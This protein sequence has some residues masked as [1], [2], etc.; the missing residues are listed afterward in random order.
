MRIQPSHVLM[1]LSAAAGVSAAGAAGRAFTAADLVGLARISDP[2]L[3]ADGRWLAYVVSELDQA[4]NKRRSDIWLQDLTQKSAPARRLTADPANDTSP[5]WAADGNYLY[6]LSARSGSTQLW[7]I[8]PRGGEAQAVSSL[9]VD[10]G[11]FK[12]APVGSR[13]V[14]SLDVYPDCADLACT[15]ERSKQDTAKQAT[16]E[17]HDQLFVRHWD[18]WDDGKRS[19]LFGAVIGADG[20]LSQPVALSAAVAAN[21]PSRPFGG[22]EEYTLSNDGERVIFSARLANASEAWSTNFDLYEVD[23]AGGGAPRNL[24]A[25]NPA[26]DSEPVYLANGDLA[27]LAMRRP[28]FES[29]RFGIM[30]RERSGKTREV[31]PQWDRSVSTLAR[32]TDGKSLLAVADDLGQHRLFKVDIGSGKVTALT[33]DGQVGGFTAGPRGIIVTQGSLVHPADLYWLGRGPATR[34]STVNDD[35]LAGISLGAAEPFTFSGW[36]NETVHGYVVRPHGYTEGKRFPVAFVVHGGP[37][38]SFQNIW[39]DRWNAQVFA[40]GGYG[41]VMIDFHGSTGYGQAFTDSISGDWGDKP[42]EDLQKGL[43]AALER[44][45]WLDGDQVCSLGASYG[46]FMQNWIA[47]KWPDRFRCIVNHAGIFDQRSMYYSTEELWFPEWENGGPYFAVPGNYEKYNPASLVENWRTPMLV[48]HGRNDYRVPY[49]QGLATFTA[50]QRRGIESRL[51]FFPDE[52]HWVLKPANSVQWY[53]E[54][55]AWLDRHLK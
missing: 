35:R 28:G 24:T 8:S 53:G 7:R 6:F 39:N 30:L 46:G 5:R 42:L 54:V 48:S 4:A 20:R 55:L 44:F 12:L 33:G 50:L 26:W 37:Q 18:S 1:V 31:A 21:V 19:Q 51:L 17:I 3:S 34:L 9:P 10:V 16:G 40:G 22:D 52:N 32:G 29:D 38:G 2:Q 15:A 45:V 49:T 25:D 27:Y 41:V 23:A 43:A 14:M 13:V 11:T 47:G 36:N